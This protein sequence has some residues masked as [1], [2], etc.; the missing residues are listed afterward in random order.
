MS[1][2][3]KLNAIKGRNQVE[4]FGMPQWANF[5][6]IEPEYFRNLNVHLLPLIT[7][8]AI[9][10]GSRILNN[11]SLTPTARCLPTMA[12]A[13]TMLPFYRAHAGTVWLEF[14]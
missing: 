12:S 3:L 2:L 7:S 11:F 14:P 10:R 8:T 9:S 1:L 6:N 5:E 13:G 4:V